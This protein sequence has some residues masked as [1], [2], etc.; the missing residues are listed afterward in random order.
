[1]VKET[2][3]SAAKNKTFDGLVI[4]KLSKNMPEFQNLI[5]L[6]LFRTKNQDLE[7]EFS[8]FN[9]IYFLHLSKSITKKMII[10]I[11]FENYRIN[12]VFPPNT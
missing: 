6:L 12:L 7:S 1:M 8:F 3:E 5:K 4:P 9:C 2:I 11:I 10:C